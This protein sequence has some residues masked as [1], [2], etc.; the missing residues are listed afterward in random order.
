MSENI[1]QRE[2]NAKRWHELV[3][4][5][6]AS[7]KSVMVFCNGHGINRHTFRYWRAKFSDL[8]SER[9]AQNSRGRFISVLRQD[10]KSA[11]PRIVLPNG[12][13][14]DLGAGLDS[15]SVNQ[16]LLNLCGV[17]LSLKED[18]DAKS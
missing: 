2:E 9:T 6:A 4:E 13:R 11:S 17:G 5:Q 14:I 1:S 7:G 16:F 8:K 10:F 15:N 12:V 3:A 18:F